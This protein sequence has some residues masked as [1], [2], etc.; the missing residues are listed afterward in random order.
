MTRRLL[1]RWGLAVVAAGAV[2]AAAVWS[3]AGRDS[4]RVPTLTVEA[5]DV[6]VRVTAEGHLE[7]VVS[8]P[9]TAPVSVRRPLTVAWTVPDGTA[10]HAGDAVVLF[11]P[12]ELEQELEDGL[13]DQRAA[14]RR[15]ATAEAERRATL[16][17]LDRDAEVARRELANA[18]EFQ[19]RDAQLYSRMEIIESSIDTELAEAKA[20]H[21]E[22]SKAIRDQL[23]EA[24]LEL[25]SIQRERAQLSI[26]QA[27]QGLDALEVVAPHDGI[28]VFER[29]WNGE[30]IRVGDSVWPG[31]PLARLP[32]LD[33]M[34]AVVFV[35]EADAGGLEQGQQSTVTLEAHPD[36]AVPATV[37]SVDPV[38]Q[39]R[40]RGVPVQY[41]RTVLELEHTDPETM[42]PGTRVHAEIVIADL[43]DAVTV[44]R[45]AVGELD[46]SPVVWRATGR[47]FESVPVTLGVTAAGRVT[48]V[49]GLQPGDRVAVRD[50][51]RT[52]PE[53][54]DDPEAGVR[55]LGGSE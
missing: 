18:R 32:E 16:E 37:R 27:N 52:R 50:P 44:P 55:A 21:A 17:K 38:A 46:G 22:T 33:E 29:D 1:L 49:E 42:K 14:E 8:T 36:L 6:R 19:N 43:E 11:D 15:L 23:A 12:T 2:L 3:L 45:Q 41:F 25:L 40:L 26:D 34:Q 7:A 20:D 4:P 31:R 51:N 53:A 9:L 5:R 28:V 30:T 47:G 10:V 13:S 39:P 24:D 48:I 54:I 35:L